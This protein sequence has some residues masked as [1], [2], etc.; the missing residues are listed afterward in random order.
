MLAGTA[1]CGSAPAAATATAPA[2]SPASPPAPAL[3][4]APAPDP[5]ATWIELDGSRMLVTTTLAA[6]G[7]PAVDLPLLIVL[8]WSRS[9]PA[10][11]LAEAG[12]VE[13]PEP[14][15]IVAIEGFVRDGA[16]H[17]WWTR[18]APA[19]P[20]PDRDTAL[21]SHLRERA[22]Q[23]AALI[24]TVHRHFGGP[25][26]VVTGLSQGAD[27][28]VALAVYHPTAITAALPI[29]GRFPSVLWP[30][31]APPGA[32]LPS[33]DAFHGTADAAASFPAFERAVAALRGRGYPATLHAFPGARHE[34]SAPMR[35]DLHACA[36]LRLRGLRTPC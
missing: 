19:P 22:P 6:R 11:V 24:E 29:A 17:S 25:R 35:A 14:A 34:V 3:A 21:V 18:G 5:A 8:G 20:D 2:S 28:S 36:A 27:L 32:A 13:I 10:E 31:A 16:G 4:S 9:N 30:P 15:R 26:A 23:V 1:S 33:L 7:R 12:Y